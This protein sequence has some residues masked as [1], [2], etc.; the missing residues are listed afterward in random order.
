MMKQRQNNNYRHLRAGLMLVL[1][2]GLS[3]AAQANLFERL[4][5]DL[6]YQDVELQ[7][8]NESFHDSIT[9]GDFTEAGLIVSEMIKGLQQADALKSAAGATAYLHAAIAAIG[10]SELDTALIAVNRSLNI[11]EQLNNNLDISLFPALQTKGE[12]LQ[13]L[14]EYTD[15]KDTFRHAQNVAHRADGVYS[16]RQLPILQNLTA[17]SIQEGDLSGADRE[18]ALAIQI[19]E[20]QYGPDSMDMIPA[21]IKAGEYFRG[22]ASQISC[23][24][25]SIKVARMVETTRGGVTSTHLA[26]ENA[27]EYF[28]RAIKIIED[29]HG[30]NDLRLI[31]PLRGLVETRVKQVHAR[32]QAEK[33][34]LRLASILEDNPDTD[35]TDLALTLIQLGDVFTITS[36]RRKARR[37]YER[38]YQ[39][40]LDTNQEELVTEYFGT[41]TRI[42]PEHAGLL[43]LERRPMDTPA[44][45]TDFYAEASFT[46]RADG[47][48]TDVKIIDGNVPNDYLKR[49]R[50]RLSESRFRPRMNSGS[51]VQT[52][53]LVMRQPF[54]VL[55]RAKPSELEVTS[56]KPGENL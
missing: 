24:S 11:S 52:E 17:I 49:L 31:A 26:Y 23:L 34:M 14:G 36:D 48:T 3:Q 16:G 35:P 39:L 9:R 30:E 4:N 56:Q 5:R 1:L 51:P 6:E 45:I 8:L 50:L 2:L 21:L 19:S 13:M 53:G 41:P 7:R 47:R 32:N 54:R 12:I 33:A 29:S 37:T 18:Q 28:N 42:Y 25:D 55:A 22:R 10:E 46:V 44:D 27:A 38:A 43:C 40:L 20:Q 15:A